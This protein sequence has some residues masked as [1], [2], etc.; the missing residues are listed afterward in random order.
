MVNSS[1]KPQTGT[2]TKPATNSVFDRAS[3]I[4][5]ERY[6]PILD[7]HE[8]LEDARLTQLKEEVTRDQRARGQM[9][10]AEQNRRVERLIAE[11]PGLRASKK[12]KD[13]D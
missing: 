9:V 12:S 8:R 10:I 1:E 5:A 11:N 13:K 3:Q 2:A 7:E 4:E 6:Q